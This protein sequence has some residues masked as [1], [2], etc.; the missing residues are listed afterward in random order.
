MCDQQFDDADHLQL[1]VNTHFD[2]EQATS[3]QYSCFVFAF[4]ISLAAYNVLNSCV[5]NYYISREA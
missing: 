5:H 2:E 4:V 1:H 3:S